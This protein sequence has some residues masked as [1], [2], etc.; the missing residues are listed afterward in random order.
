MISGLSS[1]YGTTYPYGTALFL[2]QLQSQEYANNPIFN[3]RLASSTPDPEK[4]LGDISDGKLP[5]GTDQV[6]Q[7][8]PERDISAVSSVPPSFTHLQNMADMV[9]IYNTLEYNKVVQLQEA[10][11]RAELEK[12][13][14]LQA[15]TPLPLV[16]THDAPGAS[17]PGVSTDV[18][19]QVVGRES[20]GFIATESLG[21]VLP[22][23]DTAFRPVDQ[24]SH[25]LESNTR[26]SSLTAFQPYLTSDS[27]EVLLPQAW[28]KHT[29]SQNQGQ[30]QVDRQTDG[31]NNRIRTF[32][33]QT[34]AV[35]INAGA[36]NTHGTVENAA[37]ADLPMSGR[38]DYSE[39]S[40]ASDYAVLPPRSDGHES[41]AGPQAATVV[42]EKQNGL[43][44][45]HQKKDT[46]SCSS[47]TKSDKVESVA[48]VQGR[49]SPD[50]VPERDITV[51]HNQAPSAP[52]QAPSA[53]SHQSNDGSFK[54]L[55]LKNDLQNV[56]EVTGSTPSTSTPRN[57]DVSGTGSTSSYGGRIVFIPNDSNTQN[58]IGY[59]PGLPTIPVPNQP[60]TVPLTA[61]NALHS[62][63]ILSS[64]VSL[65]GVQSTS[66]SSHQGPQEGSGYQ[67]ALHAQAIAV[68]DI[69][70][71]K[72]RY[73]MKELK[74]CTKVSSELFRP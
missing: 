4:Q 36:Y 23:A 11:A 13:K 70:V 45:I 22:Q 53:P 68:G 61:D 16:D 71:R 74:E 2:R 38:S 52:S 48:K 14:T 12:F 26:N 47:E 40:K 65:Q 60:I 7:D 39:V 9:D 15:S 35:E 57:Q 42:Y 67:S 20:G 33:P 18:S 56:S 58:V 3:S 46:V 44:Q 72:L 8:V 10:A 6:S 63:S 66:Q 69:G 21:F 31:Q 55:P 73:L 24:G 29:H 34:D 27:Q 59:I 19:G 50:E 30:V 41:G 43:F 62:G 25:S 1:I 49:G 54:I 28:L 64:G 51:Q 17:G 32:C 37:A 5:I